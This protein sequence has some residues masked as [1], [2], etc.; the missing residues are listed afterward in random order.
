MEITKEQAAQFLAAD[1]PS[2]N[3]QRDAFVRF[4]VRIFAAAEKEAANGEVGIAVFISESTSK[5]AALE[6]RVA[7][8]ESA[9]K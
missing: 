4:L 9:A 1:Q 8:L 5:L 6:A 2:A 7:A 3:G